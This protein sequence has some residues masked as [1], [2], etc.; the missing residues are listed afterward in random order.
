VEPVTHLAFELRTST[1]GPLLPALAERVEENGYR[2][3][4]VNHP[5]AAGRGSGRWSG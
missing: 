3:L 5:P 1:P 4:W 2:S